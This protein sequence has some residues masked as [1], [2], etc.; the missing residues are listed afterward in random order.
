M[1]KELAFYELAMIIAG[2]IILILVFS[3]SQVVTRSILNALRRFTNIMHQASNGD[4]SSKST[5]NI[6]KTELGIMGASLKELIDQIENFTGQI[7][8]S[9]TYA[10]KGDFTHTLSAKGMQGDFVDALNNVSIS[11][12]AMKAQDKQKQQDALNSQISALSSSVAQSLQ[13]IQDNLNNNINDLKVVTSDTKKASKLSTDSCNTVEA[14]VSDLQRLIAHVQT[15]NDAIVSLV[16]QADEITSVIEFITDIADQ[17]NLLALNAAIEAARAGEHGRGFAVVADEVRK[18]A[19][20]THKATGEISVSIKTLQQG[21]N[22]VQ[23]GSEEM[24]TIVS[25]SSEHITGFKDTLLQLNDNAN[26]IVTSSYNMENN[27]FVI[28]AK[29]D[30]IMYKSKAYSSII[31]N[32]LEL[33]IT[34]HHNCRLGIWYDSEGERRF[35]KTTSYAKV[36]PPHKIIHEYANAN[37]QFIANNTENIYTHCDTIVSNFKKMEHASEEMFNLLDDMLHEA[38]QENDESNTKN[39]TNTCNK[40][41]NSDP[42]SGDE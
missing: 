12:D 36:V 19:E 1:Q 6:D 23:S 8:E 37:M 2:V 25:A 30:H 5:I 42:S 3:M 29:I 21:M 33:D 39:K 4:F 24:A 18:L 34:D 41:K 35:S 40:S 27:I 15:S 9:L 11:V 32:N 38:N 13:V 20:R 26:S 7:N 10:A 22:D 17:T 14:I 28:L 31:N 16:S